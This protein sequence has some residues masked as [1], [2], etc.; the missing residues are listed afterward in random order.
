VVA[1]PSHCYQGRDVL[2]LA[3]LASASI[4]KDTR[5]IPDAALPPDAARIDARASAGV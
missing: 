1:R 3:R 5:L 4:E 2:R